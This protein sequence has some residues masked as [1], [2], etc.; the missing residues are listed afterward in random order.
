[1]SLLDGILAGQVE[2]VLT[3]ALEAPP[4]DTTPAFVMGKATV[5]D[6]AEGLFF[7]AKDDTRAE[8]AVTIFGTGPTGRHVRKYDGAIHTKWCGAYTAA[9]IN[10]CIG[11]Q[12]ALGGGKVIVSKG[13]YVI[14]GVGTDRIFPKSNVDIEFETGCTITTGIP[15]GLSYVF[16]IEPSTENKHNIT[17]DGNG[18]TVTGS[19][20]GHS[21]IQIGLFMGAVNSTYSIDNVKVSGFN[22]KDIRTD[23]V[24]I[25]GNV[26]TTTTRITLERV[27][28]DNCRRNGGS[29]AGSASYV[30]FIDCEFT[31]TNSDVFNIQAGFDIEVDNQA[32]GSGFQKITDI[33]FIRCRANNNQ[34]YGFYG[35]TPAYGTTSRIAFIDCEANFNGVVGSANGGYGFVANIAG[36]LLSGCRARGNSQ[37]GFSVSRVVMSDCIAEYNHGTTAG[38]RLVGSASTLSCTNTISRFNKG[39]GFVVTN[40]SPGLTS[41]TGCRAFGNYGKGYELSGALG[42]SLVQCS[43]ALNKGDGFGLFA[44]RSCILSACSAIQ[45]GCGADAS[46]DGFIVESSSHQNNLTGNTA[47]QAENFF[48]GLAVVD[49]VLT[50]VSS[51]KL[52]DWASATDDVY[53]NCMLRVVGGLQNGQS[54]LVLDY[55]GA[56]KVATLRTAIAGI[57]DGSSVIEI[58]GGTMLEA[59]V[60]TGATAT[61]VALDADIAPDLDSIFVGAYLIVTEGAGLGQAPALISVY[62]GA[63]RALTVAAMSPVCDDSSVIKIVCINRPRYG[64]RINA[65]CH[66]TKAEVNDL[67]YAGMSGAYSNAGTNTHA[68]A[69]NR[70][71]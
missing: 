58:V 25:G 49:A 11:I 71:T 19:R 12:N 68:T 24:M 38:I 4:T 35:Q 54:A 10:T 5:I 16:F 36:T 41:L 44:S 3:A 40:T 34:G 30:D 70:V 67:W 39:A 27:I 66:Y 2:A 6:G 22:F 69:A 42:T 9:A 1:M 17:I 20:T 56:T 62:N 48:H 23:G 8:N 57:P 43:A 14:T 15:T 33:R 51:I 13:A 61:V 45:N 64:M 31:N 18:C 28:S 26:G 60:Q 65:G 32:T 55:D 46:G 47:A 37:F 63:T 50:T 29:I 53:N 21:F 59:S 7:Y 52:S